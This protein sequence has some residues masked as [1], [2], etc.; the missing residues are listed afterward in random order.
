MISWFQ[1]ANI[2]LKHNLLIIFPRYIYQHYTIHLH[3][4]F[5]RHRYLQHTFP[6]SIFPACTFN[7]G[8]NAVTFEH[9]DNGNFA[10][11]LCP[12]TC[13]G[14]FDSKLGSHL[15]LFN[16]KVF[17]EFPSASTIIIP[18]SLLG[19]RN[20]PIQP[21]E[22]HVSFTQYCARGLIWWVQH[23]FQSIKACTLN[24]PQLR[25]RLESLPPGK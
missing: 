21:G 13:G 20:T 23:G 22:H 8:P 24:D 12:I 1:Q 6:N 11:G 25:E 3:C 9:V 10:G 17:I 18:S 19:H 7:V 4:L 15:I 16:W 14:A 5:S 2:L